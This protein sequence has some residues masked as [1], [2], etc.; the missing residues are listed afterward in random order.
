MTGTTRRSWG[1]RACFLTVS[2][3]AVAAL[4]LPATAVEPGDGGNV[5]GSVTV[6][7]A[8]EACILIGTTLVD[9]GTLDFGA[10]KWSGAVPAVDGYEVASCS[11]GA[12][13]FLLRV[14]DAVGGDAVWQPGG[15]ALDR[16]G[17][18]VS[19]FDRSGPNVG[20]GW[21][22]AANE[23]Y[24][25]DVPAGAQGDVIHQISMPTAGSSGAGETMTWDMIWTAV[26]AD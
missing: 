9:F 13:D 5:V 26:L 23:T 4:S 3:L 12:Q 18:S 7:P 15:P 8:P 10:A 11:G 16:F 14:T 2:V 17:I 24:W 22:G 25:P 1:R 19:I 6:T 21:L 20:V